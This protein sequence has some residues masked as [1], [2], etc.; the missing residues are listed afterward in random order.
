MKEEAHRV[1]QNNKH[2]PTGKAAT[3]NDIFAHSARNLLKIIT[4]IESL[5][6]R[7]VSHTLGWS[8]RVLNINKNEFQRILSSLLCSTPDWVSR[9]SYKTPQLHVRTIITRP[10]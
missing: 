8:F 2:S 6:E 9:I 10:V 1:P 7:G 5:L 4:R 3:S